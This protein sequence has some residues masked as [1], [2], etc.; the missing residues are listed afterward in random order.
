[1]NSLLRP[2]HGMCFQYYEG[3]GYSEDFTDHMGRVI[4]SLKADPMQTIR[5][6]AGADAVCE[7][8]PND[9]NGVCADRIKVD[10]YDAAVLRICGLRSGDTL[11][12][13]AFLS[14]VREKILNAGLRGGICGDCVWDG[15]C[16]RK[17]QTIDAEQA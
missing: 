7:K 13:G 12:Y 15:I 4:R 11:S 9:Q 14:A 5:L 6:T 2:H 16:R 8:C 3:K 17:E 10:R 1:M